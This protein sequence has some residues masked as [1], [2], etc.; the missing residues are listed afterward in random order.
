MKYFNINRHCDFSKKNCI[1]GLWV[2]YAKEADV[3]ETPAKLIDQ[4]IK[5][6][7]KH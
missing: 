4:K 6:L 7:I 3:S 5:E 1:E 2:N